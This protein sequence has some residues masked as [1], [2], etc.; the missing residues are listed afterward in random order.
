MLGTCVN[1]MYGHKKNFEE[2]G[3]SKSSLNVKKQQKMPKSAKFI[4]ENP[5]KTKWSVPNFFSTVIF[6][7]T[8]ILFYGKQKNGNKILRFFGKAGL[9]LKKQ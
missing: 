5:Y 7:S 4:F 1:L 2:D 9:G 6:F 3:N 8:D